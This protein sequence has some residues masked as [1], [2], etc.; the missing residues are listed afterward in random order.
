MPTSEKGKRY[1]IVGAGGINGWV[2][3]ATKVWLS[4]KGKKVRADSDYHG[5]LSIIFYLISVLE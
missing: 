4:D 2:D 1:C 3:G 5:G